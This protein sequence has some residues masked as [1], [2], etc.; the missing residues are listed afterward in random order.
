MFRPYSLTI[1]D[2]LHPPPHPLPPRSLAGPSV[3]P[4]YPCGP[5]TS[6]RPVI[7]YYVQCIS[8]LCS[9]RHFRWPP[10]E[11]LPLS[12]YCLDVK[13]NSLTV[14]P[15]VDQSPGLWGKFSQRFSHIGRSRGRGRLQKS[16]Q[17]GYLRS[18]SPAQKLRRRPVHL[19]KTNNCSRR[20]VPA[21]TC[22]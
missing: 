19:G 6:D 11:S 7:L 8:E 21:S 13:Y 2:R 20:T 14:I 22:L 18:V 4:R 9:S 1:A 12:F 16:V 5:D 3:C 10:R 17:R 15:L